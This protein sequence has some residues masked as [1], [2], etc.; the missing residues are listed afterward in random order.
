MAAVEC[1][2]LPLAHS[3]QTPPVRLLPDCLGCSHCMATVAH[4]PPESQVRCPVCAIRLLCWIEVSIA[5]KDLMREDQREHGHIIR[6][7]AGPEQCSQRMLMSLGDN[8]GLPWHSIRQGLWSNQRNC[9]FRWKRG[10]GLGCPVR[11]E[12]SGLVWEM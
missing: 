5:G 6:G 11:H 2:H 1:P 3:V 7:C 12:L 8:L 4:C 9:V 10:E